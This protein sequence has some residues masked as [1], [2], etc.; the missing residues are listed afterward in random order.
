MSIVAESY[1]LL[2]GVDTHA[3]THTFALVHA[4][5]GELDHVQQFPTS[6]AGLSRAVTWIQRHAHDARVLVIVDGA[7]SYGA[8]LVDRL[9]PAGLLV[10]EAPDIPA[11]TRRTSGKT[12]A[13]DAAAIARASRGLTHEQLRWPRTADHTVLR[14]L[15]TARDQ[16]ATERTRTINALTAL[17]RTVDLGVDARRA[18][19]ATTIAAIAA[20]RL[21]ARADLSTT[22]V[23]RAEAIRLARRI[24][25]LEAN[26]TA[27]HTALHTAITKSAPELLDLQGV[28]P[29]IAATVLQ[30]WSHPGRVRSEAAFAALAGVSP[31]P[32]SSGNTRRHRLNRGGDRRLNRALYIIAL[33]PHGTRP[34][35]PRLRRETHHRR[36]HQTRNHPRPQALHRP[37]ALP[38]PHHRASP[39][40]RHLTDIEASHSHRPL[41][42]AGVRLD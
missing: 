4:A 8:I 3:A 5:T 1:D 26:L 11:T 21:S 20:W 14:V 34:A 32:A 24:R 40:T 10:A 6:P 33:T 18:L 27:N 9:T 36:Q 12:D 23:W 35:H 42:D 30:A 38:H 16:M 41:A 29:V 19:T 25:A 13:V 39:A 7:S 28:G 15:T 17:L 22:A 31:L 37:A 2:I